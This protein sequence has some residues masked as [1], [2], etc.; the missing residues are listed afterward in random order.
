MFLTW[1]FFYHTVPQL[2]TDWFKTL[3]SSSNFDISLMLVIKLTKTV[4]NISNLSSTYFVS[5]ICHQH[6]CSQLNFHWQCVENAEL[7]RMLLL[8]LHVLFLSKDF[9]TPFSDPDFNTL[10]FLSG[11]FCLLGHFHLIINIVSHQLVW[12]QP[13]KLSYCHPL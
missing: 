1:Q 4:T 5:N 9:D 10:I 13:T 6:W 3:L 11:I 12:N 2:D 7:S 8:K